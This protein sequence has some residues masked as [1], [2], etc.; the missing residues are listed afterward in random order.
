MLLLY[1]VYSRL[2]FSDFFTDEP[3]PEVS[4]VSSLPVLPSTDSFFKSFSD[5]SSARP[6]SVVFGKS[7]PDLEFMTLYGSFSGAPSIIWSLLL[8]FSFPASGFHSSARICQPVMCHS[9][10]EKTCFAAGSF[11]I[12]RGEK[13]RDSAY[14]RAWLRF[15]FPRVFG[16]SQR[17]ARRPAGGLLRSAICPPC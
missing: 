3:F 17:P 10:C 1:T 15:S 5:L 2:S 16:N 9:T 13:P 11:L 4:L 7:S 12:F 8:L 14:W 6:F